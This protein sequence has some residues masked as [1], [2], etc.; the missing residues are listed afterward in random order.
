MI[1]R[2]RPERRFNGEFD[3]V[4]LA[5]EAMPHNPDLAA[6]LDLVLPGKKRLKGG[7]LPGSHRIPSIEALLRNL[8][9]RRLIKGTPYGR[10]Q[11][12]YDITE[13]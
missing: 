5:A 7:V 6:A 12:W 4:V 3:A 13:A 10:D 2:Y 1:E 11:G 9:H 8:R